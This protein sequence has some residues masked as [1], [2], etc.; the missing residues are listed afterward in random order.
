MPA[1][2]LT[3]DLAG[4]ALT[5]S[6]LSR[7]T[8]RQGGRTPYGHQ[9]GYLQQGIGYWVGTV[10][11]ERLSR[12]AHPKRGIKGIASLEAFIAEIQDGARSFRVPMPRQASPL[13]EVYDAAA[14]A[15]SFD[16]EDAGTLRTQAGGVIAAPTIGAKTAAIRIQPGT[17][18][19]VD[20]EL[21][22]AKHS[23]GE[24]VITTSKPVTIPDFPTATGKEVE[25]ASPYAVGR[26]PV[27]ADITMQRSGSWGGPWQI[28]WEEA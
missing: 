8:R 12:G 21:F 6:D 13:V 1:P 16:L 24:Q 2:D 7:M 26:V 4:V 9:S 15:T 11:F 25:L 10:G 14:P 18:L 3:L 5:R 27:G 17:R 20:H 22:V 19:T 23:A 28:A